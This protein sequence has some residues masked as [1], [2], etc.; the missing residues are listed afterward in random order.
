MYKI[1]TVF[2][3]TLTTNDKDKLLNAN[4]LIKPIQMKLF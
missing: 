3:H 2:V 1:V 4:N